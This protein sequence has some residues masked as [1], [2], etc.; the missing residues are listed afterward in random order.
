MEEQET[1]DYTLTAEAID[2][3]W[4][5]HLSNDAIL[6]MGRPGELARYLLVSHFLLQIRTAIAP[7]AEA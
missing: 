7:Y 6:V 3:W 5:G 4:N 2:Q 1:V